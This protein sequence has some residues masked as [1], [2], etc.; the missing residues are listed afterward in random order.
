M[1]KLFIGLYL[2][3]AAAIALAAWP[4][5]LPHQLG[6]RLFRALNNEYRRCL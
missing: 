1:Y 3:V 2:G 5:A 4:L 6:M